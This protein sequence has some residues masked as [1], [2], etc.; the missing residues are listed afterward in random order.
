MKHTCHWP[1]CKLEVAPSLWGCRK[2]WFML[3]ADIR[4]AI[5]KAY[6]PGQEIAKTP[7]K[8]YI[9][10]ANKAQEWIRDYEAASKIPKN[11]QPPPKPLTQQNVEPYIEPKQSANPPSSPY[12]S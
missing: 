10:A 11:P 1:S 8:E 5:I 2:H 4:Y 3:P 9:K 6:V 7:S 12:D